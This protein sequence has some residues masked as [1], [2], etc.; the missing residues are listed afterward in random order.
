MNTNCIPLHCSQIQN[1]T[2]TILTRFHPFS[3]TVRSLLS[4]HEVNC[5]NLENIS[6]I[7]G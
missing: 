5:S 6:W 1:N 3:A 4:D 2:F 7:P